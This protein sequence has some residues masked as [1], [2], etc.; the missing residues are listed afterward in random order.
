MMMLGTFQGLGF[1]QRLGFFHSPAL[2]DRVKIGLAWKFRGAGR[3]G[4][5]IITVPL[6]L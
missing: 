2:T 5:G 4:G 1:A 3:G 6:N